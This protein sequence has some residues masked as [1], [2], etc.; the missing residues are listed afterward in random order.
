MGLDSKMTPVHV[1]VLVGL[2]RLDVQI[3]TEQ[4]CG[5]IDGSEFRED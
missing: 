5:S 4:S 2:E 1:F 3:A